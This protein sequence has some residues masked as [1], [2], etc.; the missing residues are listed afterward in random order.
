MIMFSVLFA[1]AGMA[2][3]LIVAEV[4]WHRKYLKGEY[5]RKFVH[6]LGGSFVAFWPY[7]LTFQQIRFIA[8]GGI[9]V[10]LLTKTMHISYALRDIN[11]PTAGELLYPISVLLVAII[12]HDSWI[13]TTSI[14]FLS[15]ADGMAAVI[16]KRYG[17][18]KLTYNVYGG[19]KTI[20]GSLAY[21][22]CAYIAIFVGMLLGG[23]NAELQSAVLIFGWLPLACTYLENIS[24]FGTDN[25]TVPLLVVS[26]LNLALTLSLL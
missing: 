14:L 12:A 10:W 4:L 8:I 18:K 24:P 9:F 11:R 6:I 19:K 25:I 26:T 13:F 21:L 22:A 15:F 17:T 16:G 20:Q 7:F 5:A 1:L 2:L 3:V 23:K